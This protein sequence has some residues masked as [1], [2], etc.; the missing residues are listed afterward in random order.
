MKTGKSIRK[1]M[2]LGLIALLV[3]IVGKLTLFCA[4]DQPITGMKIGVVNLH[5]VLNKAK[6]RTVYEE[7][8][9]QFDESE[10]KEIRKLEDKIRD[11]QKQL[12]DIKTQESEL[13]SAIAGQM[14]ILKL[15]HEQMSRSLNQKGSKKY[16]S[17][18]ADLYNEV[19]D[20]VDKY[21]K[22]KGFTLILKTEDPRIDS[23]ESRAETISIN[24]NVRPVLYFDKTLDVTA[25]V[26]KLLNGE[27]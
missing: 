22:D 10:R 2:G 1:L 20:A 9:K 27:K 7:Q 19:R 13:W 8:I 6:K 5:E 24:M 26:I 3:V 25:D 14:E 21:A 12:N 18:M 11:H 4:P 16:N 15:Q 17:C 23:N